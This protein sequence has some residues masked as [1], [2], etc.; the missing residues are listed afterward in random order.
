MKRV[1]Q[2][3][4]GVVLFRD[5]GGTRRYLLV[6]S[7]LTRKPLWEFPKGGVETGETEAEAAERELREEA[8]LEEGDYEVRP[9]F[10]EEESYVFTRGSGPARTLVVKRVVYFLAEA[11]TDRVRLSPEAE[12]FRWADVEEAAALLRF[13]G[14]RAVLE[15]A[16]AFLAVG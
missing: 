11:R 8:G 10:R 3:A 12:E 13:A 15:Q 4:A 1:T 16:E 7:A 2:T 9:G 14:K 6:R 5:E